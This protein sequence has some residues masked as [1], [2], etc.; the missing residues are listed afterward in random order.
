MKLLLLIVTCIS[1]QGL[2]QV[3]S[4]SSMFLNMPKGKKQIKEKVDTMLDYATNQT[5]HAVDSSGHV[6]SNPIKTIFVMLIMLG[7]MIFVYMLTACCDHPS[8]NCMMWNCYNPLKCYGH[9]S[10][11]HRLIRFVRMSLL[12]SIT[13]GAVN[14][15]LLRDCDDKTLLILCDNKQS[16][17]RSFQITLW[18]VFGVLCTALRHMSSDD[19]WC[20]KAG[21]MGDVEDR[22]T[23][24]RRARMSG[25]TSRLRSVNNMVLSPTFDSNLQDVSEDE[26][27]GDSMHDR[28]TTNSPAP[29]PVVES[30]GD[31]KVKTATL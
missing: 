19:S 29:E 27:A 22:C 4:Q 24:L 31:D 12:T 17:V 11:L 10:W 28:S 14:I 6:H 7:G 30:T 16:M 8:W 18:F 26:E 1:C 2:A 5:I 25:V 15:L 13:F 9:A 3:V 21:R 20:T 23:H